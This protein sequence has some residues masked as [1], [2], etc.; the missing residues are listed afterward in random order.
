MTVTRSD[1]FLY[2]VA[3]REMVDAELW[4]SITEQQLTDYEGEWLSELFK[5]LQRLK[6]LGVQRAHW[7]QSRHW[8]WRRKTQ[9]LQGMLG[10]PSFSVVCKGVTQGMMFADLVSK[11][12]RLPEQKGR[13]LVYVD[14]VENAP[15]NRP[16]LR[17]PPLYRG[18]G[19]I[20][21]RAAIELSKSEEFKGRIGLHSLPQA[22]AFYANTIGMTDLGQDR[23]Y[24]GLRYFEMTAEHAEAF[25]KKGG[26]RP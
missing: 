14:F 13:H 11:R 20:L 15:W 24:Q 2:D 19:T 1:V 18:V 4:D 17:N 21:I 22:N 23:D 7:P 3:T 6:R 12:C 8:D 25:I 16:E 9:A 5:A 26:V 10:N